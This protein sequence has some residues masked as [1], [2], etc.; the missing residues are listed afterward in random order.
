MVE[1]VVLLATGPTYKPAHV[2]DDAERRDV[3]PPEHLQRAERDLQRRILRSAHDH[4]ASKRH[5]LGKSQRRVASP[6]RKINHEVVE[7]A[8]GYVC[9]QLL[10]G[11]RDHWAAPNHGFVSPRKEPDRDELHPI[12]LERKQFL[13]LNLRRVGH[14]EHAGHR[15]TVDVRVKKSDPCSGGL[16][17]GGGVDGGGRLAYLPL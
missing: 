17:G 14:P 3:Q 11:P 15:R 13:L 12:S 9:E 1:D 8:P 6:R 16:E 10:D 2:L 7:L 4:D 5:S